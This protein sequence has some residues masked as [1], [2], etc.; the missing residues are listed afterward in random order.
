MTTLLKPTDKNIKTAADLLK[1]GMLVALPTE[2]VYGLAASISQRDAI[3]DIFKVK[4]R[5]QDNP[6]IVH[7]TDVKMIE[8]ITQ[9]QPK[10]FY[11]LAEAFMPGPLTV[12]LE[13]NEQISD[14]VSAGLKTVAVRIPDHPITHK[15]IEK[16][17]EGIVAPSANLSGTPSPT[18]AKHAL[19]DLKGKI[20]A[21]VDGGPCDIGIESTIVNVLTDPPQI[22]RQ[23]SI[24]AEMLKEKTGTE[25]TSPTGKTKAIAP[26][27]KYRHYAPKANITLIDTN[28]KTPEK[29]D[30]NVLILSSEK[31]NMKNIYDTFRKA[32]KN[33]TKEIIIV[34]DE[35]IK[36]QLG[37]YDR[38]QRASKK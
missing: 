4:N 14:V 2:T 33:N 23:G 9:N 38:I 5:P 27:M 36:S 6:L 34:C 11:T 19:D 29:H 12:I 31:L 35:K 15:I 3:E 32:D 7:C 17:G 18:N 24:T 25:F 13:K 30:K 28:E 1:L 26:G 21:I 16:V 22:L 10:L 37:L 20:A 8:A